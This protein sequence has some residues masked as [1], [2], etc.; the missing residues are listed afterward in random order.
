[1]IIPRESVTVRKVENKEQKKE[2]NNNESRII[3]CDH[4]TIARWS[5]CL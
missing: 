4:G 5:P 1:L 3:L 2:P